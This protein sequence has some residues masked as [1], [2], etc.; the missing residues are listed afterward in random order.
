[1]KAVRIH[2]RVV[3]ELENLDLSLRTR[4]TELLSMLAEGQNLG[5]PVSRPMPVV[6]HGAHEL[7]IKDRTGAYRV[8]YFTKDAGAILVF[9]LFKKKTQE[10]PKPELE[11]AKRRLMEMR[12]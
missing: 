10:A 2:P 11:T 4:L 5:L 12:R 3:R 7:R 8:F 9:H 6:E 1:M